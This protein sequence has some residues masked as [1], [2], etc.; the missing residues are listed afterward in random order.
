MRSAL[1][2]I[3]QNL[4]TTEVGAS[5]SVSTT[6]V[7]IGSLDQTIDEQLTKLQPGDL[8][9]ELADPD[10]SIWAFIQTQLAIS[11][12]LLPPWI[13]LTV[14]GDQKFIGTINP[15]HIVRH[16]ASGTHSIELGASDWS[17]QLASTYLGSPTALP[18]QP[19]TVY[20]VGATV[21]NGGSVYIAT[22]GGTSA[23]SGG[24]SGAIPA[25]DGTVTWAYQPPSWQRPVPTIANTG[26]VVPITGFNVAWQNQTLSN[27]NA[28]AF[29]D[30][31]DSIYTGAI[32]QLIS[33]PILYATRPFKYNP[34]GGAF[35]NYYLTQILPYNV[36]TYTI[37]QL[38]APTFFPPGLLVQLSDGAG[39][40]GI[41]VQ[42]S[43]DNL[44]WVTPPYNT[45][46]PAGVYAKVNSVQDQQLMFARGV[47]GPCKATLTDVTPWPVLP[48]ASP[49]IYRTINSEA[50]FSD[51]CDGIFGSFTLTAVTAKDLD[52]WIVQVAVPSNPATPCYS[53][54]LNGVSGIVVGDSIGLVNGDQSASWTVAGV[55]PVLCQVT[56][57]EAISNVQQGSHVYW[58]PASQVE[59]VMED[60]RAIL[61]K[62]I[63]P[64][65]CDL[66][67]FVAPT[68]AD[69]MFGFLP[70]RPSS[71][72]DLWPIGDLEPTLTGLKLATGATWVDP[73]TG[74]PI[75]SYSWTGTPDLGWTGP[76]STAPAA[77]NADWTCQ[78]AAAPT[79]LMPYE[80]ATINPWQRLRNRA[81]A[82][83]T[84]RRENNGL[85]IL[86][87]SGT[88]SYALNGAYV[89]S[90]GSGGG[91]VFTYVQGGVT[92][93]SANPSDVFSPWSPVGANVAGPLAVYD[94]TQMRRVVFTGNA[95]AVTPWTGSAW[96]SP[97]NYSWPGGAWAYVQSAVPMIGTPG[98]LVAYVVDV[99]IGGTINNSLWPS[100]ITTSDRIEV[101]GLSGGVLAS[102]LV[103]VALLGSTLVT[104]PYGVFLVGAS[105][106]AQ[107]VYAA[108]VLTLTTL[109][110]ADEVDV[111]FANTLAARTPSEIVVFGRKDTQ[112]TAVATETW[113]LRIG[114][115]FQAILDA[116]VVWSEKV[117]EGSPALMGII[118]DPSKA[119]R[120]VGHLGGSL[121]QIDTARPFCIE[122]FTPGGMTALELVEHICQLFN[123]LAVPD[124]YGV[125]HII[126]RVNTDSPI[127]LTTLQTEVDSTLSWPSF[128][129][130]I[131]VSSHDSA[132]YFD[133]YGQVG[134]TLLEVANQP[135]CWSLSSCAAMAESMAAWFG[136]P[137]AHEQQT[138]TYPDA[139][140]APPWEGLPPFAKVTV[141][142]TGPWRVMGMNQDY[143][144]GTAK[145][146]LLAD[147][148]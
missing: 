106:L 75:A 16:L 121:F 33:R 44:S 132:Y 21:L 145:V 108:G 41:M 143:I 89:S 99:G 119:G 47:A 12:G 68:T 109:Y 66:S 131:R 62:A 29:V 88:S 27:P 142:G 60:P 103:P 80:V 146:T 120:L 102:L 67:K 105:S 3:W 20:G 71:G 70:L 57:L 58:T 135:L 85:I 114:V 46:A 22:V 79:S 127:A 118:R 11:G 136:K 113:M 84:Y 35:S 37:P 49:A 15:A 28:I 83:Q 115:P 30:P 128:S 137:R 95:V 122:R 48:A 91:I 92:Y 78:L 17:M 7:K 94:Y 64:F 96:G 112:G 110:L 133:A 59:M 104:T 86:V 124:A 138:W 148:A 125:M 147:P 144:N 5:C 23:A 73:S 69:P 6:L 126:S 53:L 93:T 76:V 45:S 107:V 77:P 8:T 72:N 129:S 39:G 139:T 54:L 40:L 34:G 51:C 52:Y 32:L 14:G 116:S 1:C 81:Y 97:S 134:G 140:T 42:V 13:R 130:V 90:V 74:S 55:D 24:P 141:N 61:S 98:A 10:D 9:I 25:M 100:A 56:T 43:A 65:T 26:S 38:P 63:A 19:I 2:T 123:A 4:G 101:W 31:A 36:G 87:V 18:W 111:L 117:S 50:Y 82:D